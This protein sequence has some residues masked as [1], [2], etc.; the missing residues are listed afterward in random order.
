MENKKPL[1][2]PRKHEVGK[3]TSVQFRIPKDLREIIL[4]EL[5]E[6]NKDLSYRLSMNSFLLELIQGAL[7]EQ[8]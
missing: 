6:K 7:N 8:S 1:G 2:R 4:A 5:K 3:W